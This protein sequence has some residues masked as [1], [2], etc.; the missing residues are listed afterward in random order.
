MNVALGPSWIFLSILSIQKA[1]FLQLFAC[2]SF[3]WAN[4]EC[5]CL[6]ILRSHPPEIGTE[7]RISVLSRPFQTMLDLTQASLCANRLVLLQRFRKHHYTGWVYQFGGDLFVLLWKFI[8]GAIFHRF[9]LKSSVQSSNPRCPN[10]ELNFVLLSCWELKM[11]FL[12]HH[13]R[14]VLKRLIYRLQ[15]QQGSLLLYP[16]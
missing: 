7:G 10:W 15:M 14:M 8:L 6:R 2:L 5:L 9:H 16:A 4:L 1:P 11:A 13:L 12:A 3:H